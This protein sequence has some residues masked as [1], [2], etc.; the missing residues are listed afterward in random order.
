MVYMKKFN[1]D[2]LLANVFILSYDCL[3]EITQLNLPALARKNH[4]M[5]D[6]RTNMIEQ[7][8]MNWI[9]SFVIPYNICPF[10]SHV[11]NKKSVRLHVLE[12]DDFSELLT[13]FM[14]AIDELENNEAIDTT[15]LIIPSLTCFDDYLDLVD[16]AQALLIDQGFEGQ[17]QLATFHPD[18]CFADVLKEDV[19]NYTNRSPYPML[20]LLREKS[21]EA[22][23]DFYGDTEEIPE[24]NI[25]TM[26]ELGLEKVK[27]LFEHLR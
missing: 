26:R 12:R 17:Y 13:S 2:K 11:V 19:S 6:S 9:K 15:L 22:A 5:P 21:I 25:Q 7:Q 3:K 1:N 27:K 8:T 20:H 10:A 24:K 18:Y 16:L 23:I 14:A 4:K